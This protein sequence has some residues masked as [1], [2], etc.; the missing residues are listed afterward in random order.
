MKNLMGRGDDSRKGGHADADAW[1]A[2]LRHDLVKRVVWAARDRRD[3][4][5]RPAPGELEPRLVDE[6]GRPATVAQVW[7]AL[8]DEAP[9]GVAL[10]GFQAALDAAAAAA[11]RGDVDGVLALEP[12]FDDLARR[13]RALARSVKGGR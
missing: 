4:G 5:G 6:E 2:R 8:R 12:A 1:L 9:G 10:T 13:V 3:I 7:A 11:A